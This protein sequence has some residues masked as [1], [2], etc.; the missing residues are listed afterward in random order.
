[1]KKR[2]KHG[3]LKALQEQDSLRDKTT[4]NVS[5]QR[6]MKRNRDWVKETGENE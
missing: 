6:G 4:E 5:I 3:D 1:M 2:P